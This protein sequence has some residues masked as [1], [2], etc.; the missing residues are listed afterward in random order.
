[1]GNNSRGTE[2]KKKKQKQGAKKIIG[3]IA[4]LALAIVTGGKI[5]R[6]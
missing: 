4:M 1:M 3:A 5:S 2:T 6:S